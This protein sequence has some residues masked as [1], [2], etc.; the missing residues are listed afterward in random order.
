MNPL[1]LIAGAASIDLV[2]QPL[3]PGWI[4]VLPIALLYLIIFN[5]QSRL[6]IIIGTVWCDLWSGYPFGW[7]SGAVLAAWV[8]LNFGR[9]Y[10]RIPH[11]A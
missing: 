3:F 7:I 1:L 10:F 4:W 9:K 8:I 6:A 2:L 5:D 11:V